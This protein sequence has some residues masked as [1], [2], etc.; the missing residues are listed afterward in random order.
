MRAFIATDD[1]LHLLGDGRHDFAG[2]AI[3]ALA[4]RGNTCWALI[5]GSSIQRNDDGEWREV[6]R[7]EEARGQCLAAWQGTMLIGADRARLYLVEEGVARLVESFA[8]APGRETWFTPWGGPPDVRSIAVST[9]GTAYVN[10]HVGGI[11]RS[12]PDGRWQPTIDH[13]A[14]V[15]QVVVHDG[16]VL[17][18]CAR[19]LAVSR[20]AGASWTIHAEGLHARYCRAVTVAGET[21]LVSASRGPDGLHAAIY[22]APLADP[23]RLER[24]TAGL[25]EWFADNIDTFCLAGAGRSVLAGT[26]DGTLFQS[27]DE[28]RHWRK[29]GGSL[30]PVRAIVIV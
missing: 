2:R 4:R 27:D 10:V 15:H 16:L 30:P 8:T 13:Q 25:P 9:D 11:L 29:V 17:A 1:G 22:R 21:I 18:A 20:D 26:S 28:G 19:G 6:A 24:C 3:P 14:D 7:L 12:N 5:D 23:A